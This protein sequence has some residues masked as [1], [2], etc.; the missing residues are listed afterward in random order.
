M[1]STWRISFT[2]IDQRALKTTLNYIYVASNVTLADEFSDANQ[3]MADLKAALDAVTQGN[4]Y[5]E[6]LTY[7]K[8]GSPTLPGSADVTDLAMVVCYLS[9][10]GEVPKYHTL[11]IPAPVPGLFEADGV[12]VDKTDADLVAYV[13][14][15][16]GFTVSDGEQIDTS[17]DDGIARGWWA[18]AKKSARFA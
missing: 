8:A 18:S 5:S 4:F 9:G 1:A 15:V 6:N 11:R 16:A 17:I 10:A 2:L 14:E 12:T 13:A 3:A 7:I